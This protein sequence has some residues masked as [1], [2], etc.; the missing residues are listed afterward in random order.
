MVDCVEFRYPITKPRAGCFGNLNSKP[1]V[2]SYGLRKPAETYDVYCFVD[3][4]DGKSCCVTHI[5][6]CNMCVEV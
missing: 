6:G 2:R 5:Y 1:G 3:K 4:L